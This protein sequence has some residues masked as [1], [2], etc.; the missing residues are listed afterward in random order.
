MK[1]LSISRTIDGKGGI[2]ASLC[3]KLAK[4][5]LRKREIQVL[6]IAGTSKKWDENGYGKGKRVTIGYF[7]QKG[8]PITFQDDDE[9]DPDVG[10]TVLRKVK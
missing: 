7:T 8:I 1:I 5:L 2:R 10:I 4:N 3:W 9:I 6:W